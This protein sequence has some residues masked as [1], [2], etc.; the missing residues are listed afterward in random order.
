MRNGLDFYRGPSSLLNV[1]SEFDRM[2]EEAFANSWSVVERA[3]SQ[4]AREWFNPRVDVHEN[5][6]AFFLSLDVPGVRKEDLKL[7]INGRTLTLSG[8][9]KRT[10][11][12]ERFYGKFSRSVTLPESVDLDKIEAKLEDGVLAIALPKAEATKPRTI[13]VGAGKP[14]LFAKLLSPKKTESKESEH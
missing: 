8:E 12:R 11:G 6:E 10:E 5:D 3:T 7:D 4:E 2:F 9:R 1:M 13:E 14:S